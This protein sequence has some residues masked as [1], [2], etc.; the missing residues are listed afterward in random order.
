[1]AHDRSRTHFSYRRVRIDCWLGDIPQPAD[2]GRERNPIG[3][4]TCCRWSAATRR[5][6]TSTASVPNRLPNRSTVTGVSANS[7]ISPVMASSPA[8]TAPC[9]RLIHCTPDQ[10]P[11]ASGVSLDG[12]SRSASCCSGTSASTATAAC[13]ACSSVPVIR[14]ARQSGS[15]LNVVWLD[16]QYQR[17]TS[18]GIG[19]FLRYVPRPENPQPPSGWF[20]QCSKLAVRHASCATYCTRVNSIAKRSCTL[21][22]P[23]RYQRRRAFFLSGFATKTTPAAMQPSTDPA[24]TANFPWTLRHR[25]RHA[26]VH[27][28]ATSPRNPNHFGPSIPVSLE[29]HSPLAVAAPASP[30]VCQAGWT[31]SREHDRVV[32]RKRFSHVRWNS[33]MR[34]RWQYPCTTSIASSRV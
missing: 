7:G 18:H 24:A 3:A 32:F 28:S 5:S 15:K 14:A 4:G 8:S 21:R 6:V 2:A 33:S 11:T 16:G 25:P 20:G 10:R 9:R 31:A 30:A 13:S 23:S 26:A 19:N 17:A 34:Q 1:M 29:P 12:R 27:G 22:G